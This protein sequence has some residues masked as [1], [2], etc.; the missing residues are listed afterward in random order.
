MR[1]LHPTEAPTSIRGVSPTWKLSSAG[2]V[3]P[4]DPLPGPRCS[5]Q[6]GRNGGCTPANHVDFPGPRRAPSPAQTSE[7]QSELMC[8][9]PE[10][11]DAPA[12]AWPLTTWS[13]EEVTYPRGQRDKAAPK[14]GCTLPPGQVAAV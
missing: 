14:E 7:D 1:V 13:H 3:D 5:G 10:G 11:E 9:R 6:G 8:G 2:C 12:T 4:G